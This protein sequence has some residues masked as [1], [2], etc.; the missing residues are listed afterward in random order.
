MNL[1][2]EMRGAV[3]LAT[4]DCHAIPISQAERWT[5]EVA[6]LNAIVKAAREF[7]KAHQTKSTTLIDAMY[8]LAET[9]DALDEED[10]DES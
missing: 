1:I 9:L 3:E 2:D 10:E 5:E 4:K 8:K 7:F 6:K